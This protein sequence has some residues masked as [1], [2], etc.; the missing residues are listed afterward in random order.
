[1]HPITP[2][3][4][5]ESL[6]P[7]VFGNDDPLRLALGG[8]PA[9][10]ATMDRD[11][12]YTWAFNPYGDLAAA[13]LI[14]HTDIDLYGAQAAPIRALKQRALTLGTTE[15]DLVGLMIGERWVTFDLCVTPL[16][17]PSGEI[18]GLSCL[19]IALPATCPSDAPPADAAGEP[20]APPIVERHQTVEAIRFYAQ[21]LDR[22]RHAIVAFDQDLRITYWNESAT[23]L[24]GRSAAEMFGQKLYSAVQAPH[25]H[26][27]FAE[28]WQALSRG[29]VWSG[30]VDTRNHHGRQLLLL[31]TVSPI[32]DSRGLLSG[33]ISA[34]VDLSARREIEQALR[35]SQHYRERVMEVIPAM[36]FA[37]DL[38]EDRCVFVNNQARTMLGYEP[39]LITQL[40]QGELLHLCRMQPGI[41]DLVAQIADQP[42][43]AISESEIQIIHADGSLRWIGQR[44]TIFERDSEGRP[45]Q[46]LG[47][48]IDITDRK[49][50]VERNSLLGSL[51]Q[52]I[53]SAGFDET[54]LM[55]TVVVKLA[56]HTHAGCVINLL[57]PDSYL[58]PAA[59]YHPDPA[60]N[61]R[62]EALSHISARWVP[63][64]GDQIF[65]IGNIVR[66]TPE[67]RARIARAEPELAALIGR[68]AITDMVALPLYSHGAFFGTLSLIAFDG[69]ELRLSDSVEFLQQIASSAALAVENARLFRKAQQELA[70]RDQAEESIRFQAH[71]LDLIDEAVVAIAHDGRLIYHNE[72]ARRLYSGLLPAPD[73]ITA[74]DLAQLIPHRQVQQIER[75]INRGKS[76]RGEIAFTTS[77]GQPTV[78]LV[79]SS[80]IFN[81]QGA[82]IGAMSIAT[83]ISERKRAEEDLRLV[84]TQLSELNADLQRSRDLL[85]TI[86]NGLTD[87]LLL[88]GRDGVVLAANQRIQ[89]LLGDSC[90][91]LVGH[92][93]ADRC[94]TADLQPISAC[95]MA[96]LADGQ[97]RQARVRISGLHQRLR[98]LDVLTL[99][100]LD[101]QQRLD[102]LAVHIRD[103]T[104][105]VQFEAQVIEQERFLANSRLAATVAH[106][107]NTP[108]QA[109][110]SCLH[111]A[112][113]SEGETQARYLRLARE[114]IQRIGM[115]LRQLLDLYRSH[116]LSATYV[117]L[118]ALIERV[119]LLTGSSMARQ[120]IQIIRDLEPQLPGI[121]GRAD[122]ITQVL[123]NL[124]VNATQVM[125]HG[126]VLTI[127]TRVEAPPGKTPQVRTTIADT[128]G[129]IAPDLIERIFEP[130]FTTR[131][132][133]N[134]LGLA[135]SRRI[136][137][138]HG[139][140]LTAE[141]EPCDG[142]RFSFVLPIVDV[143]MP[144]GS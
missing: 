50:E 139:G 74:F 26:L 43:G 40:D 90:Q 122:A 32:Y 119:L 93:W 134:G 106:E 59:W 18:S 52:A 25:Q 66:L 45:R 68:L 34:A 35:S 1:M 23:E 114:E 13:D 62:L 73:T 44:A 131:V 63:G 22:V 98:I 69:A 71:L 138:D 85:S 20:A 80:P 104:E 97:G 48:A 15:R 130:F 116:G 67:I 82:A 86:F 41:A 16:R 12:R 103:V 4:P 47:A 29:Q 117:D 64:L 9:S 99:P 65:S 72:A 95:I 77:D 38:V 31:V 94:Q 144:S 6:P 124:I 84:N 115:I 79:S 76:W 126:G 55:R 17:H 137:M 5:R 133:G 113:R 60:L 46:L 88:L 53:N 142:S 3:S 107:V 125:P 33:A 8:G 58:Q 36:I 108:L 10:V 87:G 27:M 118:N 14:G 70:A 136:I 121:L 37:Y 129:G 128:G 49:L 56:T 143:P 89:T 120:G 92:R 24:Y 105:Q 127:S 51:A 110:E 100:Q 75:A 7:A 2:I 140:E 102:Q 109:I 112:G 78:Q 61:A 57:A 54:D 135:V 30:E 19:S 28:I 11:L 123:L 42:D 141:S 111:L 91:L 101:G 83:D 39:D 132:D 81:D 21:L 96:S